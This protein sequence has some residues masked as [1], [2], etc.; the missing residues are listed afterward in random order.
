M[1]A[2]GTMQLN[3][4][5]AFLCLVISVGAQRNHRLTCYLDVLTHRT[6]EGPCTHIILPSISSEED[7]YRQSL[8]EDDRIILRKMKER[9]PT[10]KIL[11]GL[12]VRSSRL[13]LMSAN[14]GSVENFTQTVLT[15]LKDKSLDGLDVIW[16]DGLTSDASTRSKELFSNFLKSLKGTFDEETDPLL[17]SVSV[18]EPS[19]NSAVSYDERTLSQYVDFISI[20]PAHLENDG[21]YINKSVQHWQ[22]QQVDLQK[23]N[24][25][26]PGFLRRSRRRHHHRHHSTHDD[27]NSE[28]GK[29][30]H[31]HVL[32]LYMGGQVCQV[33]KSGEEQFITLTVLSDEHSLVKEVL[34]EGFGGIGVV[35]IDLDVFVNSICVN[36]NQD[37]RRIVE[38][39]VIMH[40]HHGRDDHHHRRDHHL[41]HHH[42]RSSHL[43]HGSHDTG[44][45]HHRHHPHRHGHHH[46]RHHHHHHHH[47]HPITPQSNMT[48][49]EQQGVE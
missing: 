13:E 10:L 26:M 43:P 16:P 46:H 44:H 23:L 28:E 40:S 14:E 47:P 29:K 9:N 39:K 49:E 36:I 6:R 15:F 19:D 12:E 11:L 37:E 20:L 33:I 1:T 21:L 17:L 4:A 42:H 30:D 18:L 22:D 2:S 35:F 27:M 38:S 7:L 24:L 3:R 25:V 34:R 32:G 48:R 41:S 31:I 45:H 8:S 5:F